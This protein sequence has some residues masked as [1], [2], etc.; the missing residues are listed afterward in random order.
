MFD[1]LKRIFNKK[2]TSVEHIVSD[3]VDSK[4]VES[5]DTVSDTTEPGCTVDLEHHTKLIS[6]IRELVGSSF[7]TIPYVRRNLQCDIL[8]DLSDSELES[9]FLSSGFYKSSEFR[10][11]TVPIFN[12]KEIPTQVDIILQ[13]VSEIG[14]VEVND[15]LDVLRTE[16]G[17]DVPFD[18]LRW[19][20]YESM[21]KPITYYPEH[22]LIFSSEESMYNYIT[23]V[24][25]SAE[26]G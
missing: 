19:L 18:Y 16:Y 20:A 12:C 11:Y 22:N 2:Q 9:L 8:I 1:F 6:E 14:P 26:N 13:L 5:I 23:K 15:L 3:D 24:R 21:E 17:L 7:F 4:P 25:R 10:S